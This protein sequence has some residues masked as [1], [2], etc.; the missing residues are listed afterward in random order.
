MERGEVMGRGGNS[1]ASVQTANKSWVTERR[2]NMLVQV[3]FEKEP[4]L[5]DVPL[6]L[7][8]VKSEEAIS[9]VKVISLPTAL[10]L[11]HWLA[12]GVPKARLEALRTAYAATMNDPEFRSEADK[13]G[14]V[15]R[16]QAGGALEDLVKQAAAAPKA[17]L[18]KTARILHW[19]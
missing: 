7:D 15:I 1:W 12:P 16:T 8:L 14:M 5:P 6:L 10:G 13:Q 11:G 4:E 2:I 3:G 18:T 9:I 19:N 17:V